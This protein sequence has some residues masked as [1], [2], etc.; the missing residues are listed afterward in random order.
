MSKSWRN[1]KEYH[2]WRK[3][4]INRDKKCVVCGTDKH[5]TAH[6]MDH[7]SYFKDERFDVDNGVTLCGQ[8]HMNFHNNYKRS[9]RVK[10]T[11]YDFHNFMSLVSYFKKDVCNGNRN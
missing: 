5:L 6:H 7:A 3:K 1:T 4:V 8:C 11:K 9:Y 2:E 10:C